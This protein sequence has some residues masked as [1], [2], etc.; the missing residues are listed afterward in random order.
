MSPVLRTGIIGAG[1]ISGMHLPVLASMEGVKI[2]CICDIIPERA[3]SA[4]EAYGC[5]FMTDWE[6]MIARTDIDVIHVL[7]PHYL[8]ARMAIAALQHGKHVLVEK[9]MASELADARRMI[10]ESD[11]RPNQRLGIIF[12]NRFN[13]STVALKQIIESGE[14]GAF[15]GARASVTWHREA[16]YYTESGWRGKM[17]TEG[18]GVLINQAIHT[19]DLL[20]YLGGPI[21]RVRGQVSTILLEDAID[22]EDN[23]HAVMEYANGKTAVLHATNNY[24]TDAPIVLEVMLEKATYQLLGDKLLVL[25]DGIPTLVQ[26]GKAPTVAEKAYWGAGHAAQLLNFYNSIRSDEPLAV[27]A[28]EGYP[29]LNLVKAIYTSSATG[30]WVTLDEV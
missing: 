7:T 21:K 5:E 26:E 12:Q 13:P 16:P 9:P 24:V 23:A 11:S 4:A 19:L 25:K 20:S 14:Y 28:R 1:A 10:M 8:H 3:Q 18:G 29:G 22:V 30:S 27:N 15:I 2:A 6:Q 17:A